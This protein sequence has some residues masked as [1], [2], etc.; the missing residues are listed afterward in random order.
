MKY[1]GIHYLLKLH[2]FY[3][4]LDSNPLKSSLDRVTRDTD[5]LLSNDLYSPS[6]NDLDHHIEK[7]AIGKQQALIQYLLK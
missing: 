7:R 6:E 3:I 5:K 1:G 2:L 4:F